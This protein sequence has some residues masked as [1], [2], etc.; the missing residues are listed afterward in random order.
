M[1]GASLRLCSYHPYSG[2]RGVGELPARNWAFKRCVPA[3]LCPLGQEGQT[4]RQDSEPARKGAPL[5]HDPGWHELHDQAPGEERGK[6]CGSIPDD[7]H[8]RVP[9]MRGGAGG[10]AL[11][12][13]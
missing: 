7:L 2:C 6:P 13:D 9:R 8:D 12:D 3:L 1:H 5:G 4:H 11:A 10:A